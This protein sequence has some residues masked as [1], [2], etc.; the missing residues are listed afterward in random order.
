MIQ[1][2]VKKY[3][4]TLL[5]RVQKIVDSDYHASAAL[6]ELYQGLPAAVD[7]YTMPNGAVVGLVKL[8]SSEH[9]VEVF[10]GEYETV[11]G[12]L[13]NRTFDYMLP[14]YP[15]H[16]TSDAEIDATIKC[17]IEDRLR[18]I[19]FSHYLKDVV[20]GIV[21]IEG[22]ISEI[23]K[24]NPWLSKQFGELTTLLSDTRK[25]AEDLSR[26]STESRE[27]LRYE[28]Y[29]EMVGYLESYDPGTS[30]KQLDGIDLEKVRTFMTEFIRSY[31]ATIDAK[32]LAREAFPPFYADY[33][34][35]VELNLLPNKN[36]AV[37]FTKATEGMRFTDRQ[38]GFNE[39]ENEV[40]DKSFTYALGLP[41]CIAFNKT[42]AVHQ[43]QL[44]AQIDLERHDIHLSLEAIPTSLAGIEKQ[45]I[46]I[47]K[48][49][50]WLEQNLS[51]LLK[52]LET[53]TKPVKKL[54]SRIDKRRKAGIVLRSY[55]NQYDSSI[56]VFASSGELRAAAPVYEDVETAH[57]ATPQ[58]AFVP[59]MT[60]A[61][62][63]A[64][65][66][67]VMAPAPSYGSGS[68]EYEL[69]IPM[70][71]MDVPTVPRMEASDM[72]SGD[73]NEIKSMLYTFERK[74]ADYEKRLHY[75]DK[76][77]EMIQR[78]QNKKFKAQKDLIAL[79]SRKGKWLGV[80]IG[81]SALTIAVV[82][83]L[84]N[85]NE[86]LDLITTLLGG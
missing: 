21:N 3:Y 63:A 46:K 86:L 30:P 72:G 60:T 5:A 28:S 14:I 47:K 39:F 56:S 45:I 32:S 49:N 55:V 75:I 22:Q 7:A 29:E 11:K 6:I 66:P 43:A 51:E 65:P 69:Q 62:A 70:G 84:V 42:G 44:Q 73:L 23:S 33:P 78:Q 77:T 83:L 50:P 53:C 76:Y 48:S 26:S 38:L 74:L 18:G 81:A 82:L 41:N 4:D 80:G 59:A 2:D 35:K 54:L 67:V 37:F 8:N 40:K 57:L 10:S 9:R 71:G 15:S 52:T 36:V 85:Y 34:Y 12:E 79:E 16:P 17:H 24:T 1:A 58:G 13:R 64:P 31:R 68:G 25:R 61:P 27:R 19:D 20:L